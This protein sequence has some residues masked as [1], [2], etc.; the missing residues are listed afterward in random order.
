MS[1]AIKS[2]GPREAVTRALLANDT[3][4]LK[5]RE[6]IV[7]ILN[8]PE[9][10]QTDPPRPPAPPKDYALVDGFGDSTGIGR[11]VVEVFAVE[12]MPK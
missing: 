8:T 3:I 4:P 11:L 7:D 9:D 1:W 6:G 5:L 12:A 10:P 2:I